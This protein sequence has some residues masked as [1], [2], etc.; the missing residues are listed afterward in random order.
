MNVTRCYSAKRCFVAKHARCIV[1][2]LLV[3]ACVLPVACSVEVERPDKLPTTAELRGW[4]LDEIRDLED[5]IARK[6]YRVPGKVK[7][8]ARRLAGIEVNLTL[9]PGQQYHNP[10]EAREAVLRVVDRLRDWHD[11]SLGRRKDTDADRAELQVILDEAKS[12]LANI[13]VGN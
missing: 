5:A 6:D 11:R 12:V 7:G 13:K 8:F 1:L 4:R 2:A 10:D 3:V 9:G